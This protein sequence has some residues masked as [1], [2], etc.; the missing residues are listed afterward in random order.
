MRRIR[1]SSPWNDIVLFQ[2]EDRDITL[3][4]DYWLRFALWILLRV[5]SCFYNRVVTSYRC[6]AASD[7]TILLSAASVTPVI[8]TQPPRQQLLLHES[9]F[10]KD[11]ST[12]YDWFGLD[13]KKVLSFFYTSVD[14]YSIIYLYPN[15]NYIIISVF[16]CFFW[17]SDNKNLFYS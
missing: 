16:C 1:H 6:Y 13:E 5:C 17:N 2:M 14:I 3:W 9:S 8:K 10:Y 15:M 11:V 7:F 12:F 4:K